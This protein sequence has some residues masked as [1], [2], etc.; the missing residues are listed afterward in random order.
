MKG[1]YQ[2]SRKGSGFSNLTGTLSTWVLGADLF[3]P[4]TQMLKL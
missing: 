2:Q 4:K 1:V 3:P